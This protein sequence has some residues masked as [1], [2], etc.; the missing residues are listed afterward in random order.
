MVDLR[1]D[2]SEGFALRW[3]DF[4]R[5]DGAARLIGRQ[6]YFAKTGAG[7]WGEEANVICDFQQ[8]D[9]DSI[10]RAMG[11]DKRVM[12]RESFEFIWRGDERQACV[13]GNFFGK[14][15]SKTRFGVEACPNRRA[16]LRERVKF[17]EPPF[18]PRN[19]EVELR[20]I[21]RKFL[22]ERD[23]GGVLCMGTADFDDLGKALGFIIQGIAE[24]LQ[25]RKQPMR[26]LLC[27]ADVHGR[28]ERI[29]WGLAAVHM[30]IRVNRV[31][32]AN[33]AAED[34]DGFIGDDFIGVH[35][36][37]R[38]RACLPDRKREIIV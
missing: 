29:V 21:T 28:W 16:A 3:V 8:A 17:C 37:L 32:G 20:N 31:F 19:A 4:A 27:C 38:A 30:V 5:H 14:A 23:G 12:R 11:W 2:H 25:F 36:G 33:H 13:I 1:A 6:R 34:F 9:R 15:L 18:D 22:A 7:P 10:Q 26:D 35:I 24:D